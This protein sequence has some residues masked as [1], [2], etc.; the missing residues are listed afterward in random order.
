MHLVC[1]EGC[2]PFHSLL[3]LCAAPPLW[4]LQVARQR[5]YHRHF[6]ISPWSI[7]LPDCPGSIEAEETAALGL[8]LFLAGSRAGVVCQCGLVVQAEG[9]DVTGAEQQSSVSWQFQSIPELSTGATAQSQLLLFQKLQC[10]YL[11][12]DLFP[13]VKTFVRTGSFTWGRAVWFDIHRASCQN[14]NRTWGCAL[15]VLKFRD[16]AGIIRHS[17]AISLWINL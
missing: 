11:A 2:L 14:R 3:Q 13:W 9:A 5:M 4:L 8:E 12:S 10:F 6:I 7:T 17:S 16:F 1:G 15:K